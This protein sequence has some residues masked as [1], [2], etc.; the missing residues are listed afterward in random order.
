MEIIDF[1]GKVVY[2]RKVYDVE[3]ITII[4]LSFLPNSIY[5]IH[6]F[7]GEK[8]YCNKIILQK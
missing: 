2:L 6:I 3:N 1:L 5:T 4:D 7:N 8:S